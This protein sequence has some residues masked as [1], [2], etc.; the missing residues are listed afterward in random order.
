MGALTEY[1]LARFVVEVE[2][3]CVHAYDAYGRVYT[4]MGNEEGME[5]MIEGIFFN[6][7]AFLTHTGNL[8]K[9]LWPMKPRRKSGESDQAYQQRSTD[10]EDRGKTLRAE[11][12]VEDDSSLESRKLRDHLEHYDERL[13]EFIRA[14]HPQGLIDMAISPPQS[15][16]QS[17]I[18]YH[19]LFDPAQMRFIY[20]NDVIELI[21]VSHAVLELRAAAKEW[22]FTHGVWNR[23]Y[24]GAW[25]NR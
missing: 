20:Q 2:L 21:G 13:E 7:H 8:S 14:P 1:Q 9:L 12:D 5:K 16:V 3:Q 22:L 24:S 19:R 25:Y 23:E 17:G 10:Q 4:A 15:D 11:L 18:V 6:V